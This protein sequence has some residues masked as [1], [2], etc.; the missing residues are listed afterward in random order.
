MP[1]VQQTASGVSNALP[2]VQQAA[3][4]QPSTAVPGEPAVQ[5]PDSGV[6]TDYSTSTVLPEIKD[7]SL[8]HK[9]ID[10]ELKYDELMSLA[11]KGMDQMTDWTE[12]I[13]EQPVTPS[14][15]L[16]FSNHELDELRKGLQSTPKSPKIKIGTGIP[17]FSHP[18][19]SKSLKRSE[20]SPTGSS[21]DT[22]KAKGPQE[23]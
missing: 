1:A 3:A 20:I 15:F 9:T 22:K 8:Q 2:G 10:Q 11:A 4:S 12:E 17:K 21:Q 18:S 14:K 13:E 6:V 16:E 23:V 5:L 7:D 19:R